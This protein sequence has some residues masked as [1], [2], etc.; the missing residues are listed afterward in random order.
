MDVERTELEVLSGAKNILLKNKCFVQI[1]YGTE[2]RN[3]IDIFFK[4]INYKKIVY[5]QSDNNEC[6]FSNF[7]EQKDIN[8]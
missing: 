2:Y 1:E 5:E 8:L 3:K 7:I 4:D 6:F